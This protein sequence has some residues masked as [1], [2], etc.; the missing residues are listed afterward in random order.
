VERAVA[1]IDELLSDRQSPD[2]YWAW[3]ARRAASTDT[4]GEPV[5]QGHTLRRRYLQVRGKPVELPDGWVLAVRSVHPTTEMLAF[6]VSSNLSLQLT[7][8]LLTYLT[9]VRPPLPEGLARVNRWLF[10]LQ[11]VLESLPREC[12]SYGLY[13]VRLPHYRLKNAFFPVDYAPM[14]DGTAHYREYLVL[15]WYHQVQVASLG[16]AQALDDLQFTTLGYQSRLRQSYESVY[17]SPERFLAWVNERT[18]GARPRAD[19]A[20]HFTELLSKVLYD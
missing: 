9:A 10:D 2:G 6:P 14:L 8:S 15:G 3:L 20:A 5:W 16:S 7:G 17:R 11:Q 18:A 4:L 1:F 12:T 13:V 19:L